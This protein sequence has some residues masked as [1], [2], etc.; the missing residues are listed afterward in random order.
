MVLP[1]AFTMGSCSAPWAQGEHS[2]C[3]S[4]PLPPGRVPVCV[5]SPSLSVS[6]W[7]QPFFFFSCASIL[8][9]QNAKE[10]GYQSLVI[11]MVHSPASK[12]AVERNSGG[13]NQKRGW[14]RLNGCYKY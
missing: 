10:Y 8:V 14:V 13:G 4:E 2:C 6:S 5:N 12:L 3:D 7:H 9:Q 1:L 11:R